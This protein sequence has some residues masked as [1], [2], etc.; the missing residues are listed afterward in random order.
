[1]QRTASDAVRTVAWVVTV[2]ASLACC[3]KTRTPKEHS[4]AIRAMQFDPAVVDVRVGDTIVWTNEDVVPHT[5]T[6][7]GEFDSQELAT[8]QQWRYT[9]TK[10]GETIYKCTYH[11]TMYGTIKA[12][13]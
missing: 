2:T 4:V 9:V 5:A 1:M 11:P 10:A 13:D 6:A 7:T 3:S 12:A 8:R